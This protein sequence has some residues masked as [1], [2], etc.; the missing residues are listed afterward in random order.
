MRRRL[1]FFIALCAL[2]SLVLASACYHSSNDQVPNQNA[3]ATPTN[4]PDN[5]T[6]DST[7]ATNSDV[8]SD[9]PPG[10][11][12]VDFFGKGDVFIKK[13]G[14]Q[15]FMPRLHDSFSIG[16][17]LK[18]GEAPSFVSV[19]C[20]DRLCKLYT[21]EYDTCCSA[22]CTQVA[23]MMRIA[24][25]DNPPVVKKADLS[26]ADAKTLNDAESNIRSLDLGPVTTQFLVTT[27]YSGWKLEETNHELDRLTIQLAT[28]QAKQELQQSYLPIIR[29]TG[30]MQ[31]KVN[32]I[33]KAKELYQIDISSSSENPIEKAAAHARLAEAYKESGDKTEAVRNYEIA[34]DIYVKQGE[35]RAAVATEKQITNTQAIQRTD[36][37]TLRKGQAGATKSP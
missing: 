6:S 20:P 31:R 9:Q 16:D 26:P 17:R 14:S 33:E 34:K 5:K 27:M 10:L 25:G 7:N 37:T 28:P 22:S 35:T 3:A 8:S 29:K 11:D 36:K 18:I 23:P 24:A 13:R 30:D 1:S 12:A 2:A 15:S 19:L 32:R 21:G 4:T